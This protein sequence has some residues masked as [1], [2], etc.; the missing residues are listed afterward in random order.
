MTVLGAS[1]LTGCGFLLGGPEPDR[2]PE[3]DRTA[4]PQ[5]AALTPAQDYAGEILAYFLQIV[6]GHIGT[7]ERRQAWKSTG[8]DFPL[9]Y[10]AISR[11]M[12]RPASRKTDLMVLDY[13]LSALVEVL[14][15]YNPRFNLFKGQAIFS[16]VYPSSEL[17]ALRLLIQRKLLSG[18]QVS[19]TALQTHEALLHPDATL[20][21]A[22]DLQDMNLSAGEF[23]LVK[24]V[25]AS[26][27]LFF[28][29]YKHPFI[30][31]AMARVGF[32][33]K[34]ALT[35]AIRRNA[36]YDRYAPGDG[37]S[38]GGKTIE[39]V[40]LPS[41]NRQFEFGGQYAPD[42]R[43]GFKPSENYLRTVDT[44]NEKIL[45][46][47][48]QLLYAE[49]KANGSS[50][51]ENDAAF[52]RLWDHTY[53]PMIRFRSFHQRPLTIYPENNDHLVKQ[54]APAADVVI[55]LLGSGVERAIDTSRTAEEFSATGRFYFSIDDI[56]YYRRNDAID[57][58]A[59]HIVGRL[60]P[61]RAVAA[62][63]Q[64]ANIL[65]TIQRNSEVC[66]ESMCW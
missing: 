1:I 7:E 57:K 29:Y 10:H 18:E 13:D 31:D 46:R 25:F 32:Y 20:P 34:E 16:S 12:N 59:R 64:T 35:E 48:A 4:G 26:D 30:V 21:S 58:I 41:F 6:V 43:Y 37:H 53:A 50:S 66:T 47:T 38:G 22:A 8:A 54:V 2:V 9:D 49:R 45:A 51:V 61:L 63:L 19:F 15:Y 56:R 62:P 39:V 27:P 52:K 33:Q 60:Q 24:E 42:F 65:Q 11:V 36:S 44:L 14:S 23:Q 28:L 5:A 17:I 40:V 55:I 3:P